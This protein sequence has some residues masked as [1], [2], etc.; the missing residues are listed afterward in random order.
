M[1]SS[2]LSLLS[3]KCEAW[4]PFILR[5]L[6]SSQLLCKALT[7]PVCDLVVVDRLG[8]A[9]V[10]LVEAEDR[11]LPLLVVRRNKTLGMA[12]RL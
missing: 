7:L 2:P 3:T 8:T 6:P 10:Y 1:K 12:R 11:W 9:T 5:P 4:P